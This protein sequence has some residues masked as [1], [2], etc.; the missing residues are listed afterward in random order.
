M[1]DYLYHYFLTRKPL[2]KK[3]PLPRWIRW[4]LYKYLKKN[5]VRNY[6]NM[7]LASLDIDS[8]SNVIVSLTSFPARIEVV[9][10]SIRCILNQTR[11]PQKVV[12][13]LGKE[14]FPEGKNNLP[15]SLLELT[16]C[17]LEIEFCE[18]IG[19]HSKYFYAFQKYPN[20]LIVT[21]DDDIFYPEK[22]LEVLIDTHQKHPNCVAA[23]RVRLME[24]DQEGLEPYRY[25][26]INNLPHHKPS[27]LLFATGVSGVLYKPSFFLKSLYDKIGITKTNCLGDDI[28]LKAGQIA[29]DVPVVFTNIFFKRFIE[30]PESQKV[31][32]FRKNVIE[33]DNDRQ[34]KEVFD[35]F[36]IVE[37][38]FK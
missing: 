23:N 29:N 35:Y 5:L 20:N 13:W 32:L 15:N 24:A 33:S 8:K 37:S 11:K 4:Q 28:W 7:P 38:S 22:M 10:L 16:S 36:G 25:W 12:L 34:I 3:N 18:D 9:Y 27:K 1:I 6:K 19:A 2:T 21:V 26:K 31:S 17:G 30:I 14:K